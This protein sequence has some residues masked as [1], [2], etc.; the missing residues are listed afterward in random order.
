MTNMQVN[1]IPQT[2]SFFS[3]QEFIKMPDHQIKIS[4]NNNNNILD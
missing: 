3:K 1:T 2:A 4:I